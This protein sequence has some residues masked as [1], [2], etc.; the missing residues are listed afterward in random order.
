MKKKLFSIFL[1]MFIAIYAI[2]SVRNVFAETG[3][4]VGE[5][6]TCQFLE[7]DIEFEF[8]SDNSADITISDKSKLY[9][10]EKDTIKVSV[11][12][13]DISYDIGDGFFLDFHSYYKLET[14]KKVITNKALIFKRFY[15]NEE[16]NSDV[17]DTIYYVVDVENDKFYIITNTKENKA[18][19]LNND[20]EIIDGIFLVNYETWDDYDDFKLI[21]D[22]FEDYPVIAGNITKLE[23]NN[24]V[25]GATLN[26]TLEDLKTKISFTE[27][28]QNL[29]ASG[30]NLSIF[31]DANDISN[32]VTDTDKK[33]ILAK[34]ND[35]KIGM[36][37]DIN[38][39]KQI[40]GLEKSKVSNTN[41]L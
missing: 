16:N 37:L 39:Y 18:M 33:L 27:E 38:L 17:Y 24:N 12:Q 4:Y 22:K 41:G 19:Y 20:S 30:K 29:I 2:T 25:G 21:L 8:T 26:N 3:E 15:Y 5:F 28:E 10:N 7:A 9:T 1:F 23:R 35:K 6:N 34:A 13:D 14:S 11:F 31:L 32:T 36:Y 40:D